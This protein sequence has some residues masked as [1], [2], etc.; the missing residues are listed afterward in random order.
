M[1]TRYAHASTAFEETLEGLDLPDDSLVDAD[2]QSELGRRAALVAV[3]ELEW[4]KRLGGLLKWSEVA[5]LLGTVKTRQGINDLGKRR[6]LLA[7]STKTGQVVYPAF[8]FAG[9]RP[10]RHLPEL[11]SAFSAANPSPWTVA[12]WLVTPHRLLDDATPAQWLK[13]EH[14]PA[15]VLEAAGR[16]AARLEH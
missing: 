7:L 2:A 5:D 6:R 3:A 9:G 10:L 13:R 14:D 8:Q 16:L 4:T 15:P 1:A 11:L 12:S